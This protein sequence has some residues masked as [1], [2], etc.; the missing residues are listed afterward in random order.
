MVD[1]H[2]KVVYCVKKGKLYFK[3]TKGADLNL[4]VVIINTLS[5]PLHKGFPGWCNGKLTGEHRTFAMDTNTAIARRRKSSGMLV[6]QRLEV[7]RLISQPHQPA[8]TAII[9]LICAGEPQQT[10]I[11]LKN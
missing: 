2:F 6:G 7:L 9:K 5:I 1:L 11:K 4:L 8:E 10:L 3:C